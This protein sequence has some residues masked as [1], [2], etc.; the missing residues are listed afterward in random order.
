MLF[1]GLTA[2]VLLG[3]LS[4]IASTFPAPA[5]TPAAVVTSTHNIYL[6]SCVPRNSSV[7]TTGANFTAIA[8]F[9]QPLNASELVGEKDPKTD[10]AAVV[11]DPASAWEGVKWRVKVWRDKMF[12]TEIPAGS[13]ALEKGQ[14]AGTV[15]LDAEHFV[16]FRDGQ[17]GIRVREDDGPRGNCVADYWCPSIDPKKEKDD[18]KRE[19]EVLGV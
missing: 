19:L 12:A 2:A 10:H 14:L 5:N 1:Q 7:G 15:T 11:S 13:D 3:C 9:R 6:V 4:H 17:T 18:T 16:C 8:Y